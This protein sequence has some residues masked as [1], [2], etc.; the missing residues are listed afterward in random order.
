MILSENRCTLFGIMLR[1][2]ASG[3]P[4]AVVLALS[5]VL[6]AAA[7]E[8]D[9]KELAPTGKLRVALVFA[10]EKS[11]FFVVKDGEGKPRG[12]TADIAGA[13]AQ[14]SKL[15]LEFVLFPNSGLATDA[16]ESGAVDVSFMPVDEERKQ[17]VAFGPNYVLGE[18]TYMVT[19]A[20]PAKTVE[21]VDR[22]GV[23]V[24]GIANT[25]TIRAA[26]RTLK[27]TT[28]APLP[29][30]AEAVAMMRDGKADAFA[31]SRDSLPTYL[32]QVP[33]SRITDGAFQQIG[34][35][36]AVAKGNQ[37]GLAA[38]TSFMNEAKRNGVV[39]KALD[40]AGYSDIAV[41]P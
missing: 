26:A 28:V 29:S 2:L 30:V 6:S 3:F 35:A 32:N 15:P 31:L 11:I 21:E 22:A 10:P 5:L 8:D 9:V 34:I 27:N 4:I 40:G 17:R 24:I 39:R 37:A 33:G 36:I 13:L 19:A 20:L 18:S 1:A 38:V 41:A 12:V 23:R 16:L 7:R 14:A 25:T